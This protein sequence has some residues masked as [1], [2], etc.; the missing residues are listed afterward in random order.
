MGTPIKYYKATLKP[1]V[2]D[3]DIVV[4]HEPFDASIEMYLKTASELAVEN[5]L[6]PISTLA[7]RLG[8]STVSATEMVHRLCDRHLLDHTPYKGVALTSDGDRRAH[9]VIRRHRLW[10]CFLV[11]HLG[12]SWQKVHDSACQLEH[13]TTDEVAEAL[14]VFLGEPPTC[15]HGNPIP[16][17]YGELAQIQD[18]PLRQWEPGD[19]GRITRIHPESFELLDYLAGHQMMPGHSVVFD[20][21]APFDGPMMLH[22]NGQSQALG[23]EIATHIYG[24]RDHE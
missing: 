20:E 3:A 5:E 8:V 4:K 21:I 19:R 17:P 6:V 9:A 1:G 13:A 22:I 10:E 16:G 15:P 18:Q 7:E 24:I 2:P 12:L 14:A 23:R 11:D